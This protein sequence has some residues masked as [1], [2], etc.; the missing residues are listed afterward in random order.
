MLPYV[1]HYPWRAQ[2]PQALA[3]PSMSPADGGFAVAVVGAVVRRRWMSCARS[4]VAC[5]G[6]Q[7]CADYRLLR[8]GSTS[9][10]PG[11]A[12]MAARRQSMIWGLQ[13]YLRPARRC[14]SDAPFVGTIELSIAAA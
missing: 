14:G 10:Q 8:L 2:Y 12:W 9:R 4:V 1:L 6:S 11:I 3:P 5:S 13:P 7:K